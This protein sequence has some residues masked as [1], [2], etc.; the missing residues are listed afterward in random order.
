MA[1]TDEGSSSGLSWTVDPQAGLSTIRLRGELDL[2]SA[3]ALE[4]VLAEHV[5]VTSVTVIDL[6]GLEFMDSTGLRILARAH[7][8]VRGSGDRFLLGRPSPA[9]V[10]VLQVAGLVE[11]FDY[12]EG[13][14]PRERVCQVCDEWVA[15]PGV[16]CPHCGSCA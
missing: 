14:P 1:A 16:K 10:R 3:P 6:E 13:A 9:V 8:S 2:S 15:S 4:G 12:V 7:Q 11:H 5:G